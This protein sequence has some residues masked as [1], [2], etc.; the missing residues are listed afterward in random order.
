MQRYPESSK[1]ITGVSNRPEVFRYVGKPHAQ[2]MAKNNLSLEE[3]T[4][5][6]EG[7]PADGEHFRLTDNDGQEYEVYYVSFDPND[8]S[9]DAEIPVPVGCTFNVSGDNKH[10]FIVTAELD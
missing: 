4:E 1:D 5:L 2:Y 9:P 10:G 3:Y 6:L 8:S 7:Y